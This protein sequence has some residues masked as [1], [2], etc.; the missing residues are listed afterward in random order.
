MNCVYLIA[1]GVRFCPDPSC[2]ADRPTEK[3]NRAVRGRAVVVMSTPSVV[4]GALVLRGD[5][6]PSVTYPPAGPYPNN[7]P[8]PCPRTT[9]TIR[10]ELS[11]SATD[12]AGRSSTERHVRRMSTSHRPTLTMNRRTNA[13]RQRRSRPDE[14]AL[15][16]E[17]L[18]I[19][20]PGRAGFGEHSLRPGRAGR[21]AVLRGARRRASA[22]GAVPGAGPL[23]RR[24]RQVVAR[25]PAAGSAG[26]RGQRATVRCDE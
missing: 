20:P 4:C 9:Q 15:F 5:V 16:R 2:A 14:Y 24:Q 26:Q 10:I 8:A 7:A 3:S 1:P 12:F 25:A 19:R 22:A 13:A 17:A 11:A 23:A 18:A 6:L 21:S